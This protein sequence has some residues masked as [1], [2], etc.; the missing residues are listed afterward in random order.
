MSQQRAWRSTRAA[1]GPEVPGS[2]PGHA[3]PLLLL[4]LLLLCPDS[5]GFGLPDLRRGA[6]NVRLPRRAPRFSVSPKK[7]RSSEPP[8]LTSP[9]DT[10]PVS[11]KSSDRVCALILV[12]GVDPRIKTQIVSYQTHIVSYKAQLCLIRHKNVSYKTQKCVL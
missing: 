10:A 6:T 5:L 12:R 9:I 8:A 4:L 2:R 1:G 7:L 11:S 3:P